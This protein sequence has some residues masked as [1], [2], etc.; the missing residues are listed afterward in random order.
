TLGA[1]GITEAIFSCLC[2]ENNFMPASLNTEDK[3]SELT[4]NVL[5]KKN[6]S[7][8]NTVISNSFGFGGTNCS[9]AIGRRT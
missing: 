4:A 5:M 1:A 2:I 9:L 6:E 8:V 3:D 7:P